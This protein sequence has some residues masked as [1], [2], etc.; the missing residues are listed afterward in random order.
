MSYPTSASSNAT[1][2]TF[3]PTTG[4]P[5]RQQPKPLTAKEAIAANVKVLIQQL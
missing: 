2:S 4:N 5:K 3:A 1:T